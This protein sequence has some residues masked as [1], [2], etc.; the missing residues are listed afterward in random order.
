MKK[1]FFIPIIILLTVEVSAQDQN[2]AAITDSLLS[3]Y[4]DEAKPYILK[5]AEG[6]IDPKITDERVREISLET[7]VGLIESNHNLVRQYVLNEIN[8]D[9]SLNIAQINNLIQNKYERFY[10]SLDYIYYSKVNKR[11]KTLIIEQ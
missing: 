5:M 8:N 4:K 2:I 10:P 7:I 11:V 3:I 6:R 1:L 9:S